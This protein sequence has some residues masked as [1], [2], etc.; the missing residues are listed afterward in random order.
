MV[1]ITGTSGSLNHTATIAL[2][3]SSQ[4]GTVT[5]TPV[6]SSDSPYYIEEDLKLANTAPVTAL[7]IT[8]NVAVTPGLGINGEYN[9][10]G[11]IITQA[12]SSTASTLTYTYTLNPGQTL[13]AGSYLF[14]AQ[15]SGTGTAHP[16]S[17][18]TYSVTST[19]G[20]TTTTQTGVF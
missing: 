19:A 5:V 17:G 11:G 12:D 14:A 6:V 10:V 13:S 1:T 7:S 16:V 2:T 3:I 8:I 20:G 15:M 18:D 9:T 4:G